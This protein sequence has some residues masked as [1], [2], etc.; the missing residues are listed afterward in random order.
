MPKKMF[1]AGLSF[2]FAVTLVVNGSSVNL[3]SVGEINNEN[4]LQPPTVVINIEPFSTIFEG[5]IV[6]C[7]ISGEVTYRFWRINDG[8]P[9]TLFYDDDPIIF[10]PDPTPLDEDYV[11]FTVYAENNDGSAQQTIKVMI[12]RLF[13]GDLHFHSRISDGRYTA[14]TMYDNAVADNYLDFAALTNHA[15][16]IDSVE[17]IAPMVFKYLLFI[18]PMVFKD[19]FQIL[20]CKLLGTSE[21]EITK[22]KADEYYDPGRFTTFLGFEYGPGPFHPG[23]HKWS[24]NGHEDISHL[25]F[26]YKDVNSDSCKYSAWTDYTYDDIFQS[27]KE[28]WDKGNLNIGFPHHPVLFNGFE[29]NTVNWTF[30]A[31]EMV[32]KESRGQVLRGVEVYSCWGTSIGK[33][34]DIPI[35]FPYPSNRIYDQMDAWVENAMWM[36]SSDSLKG[37]KFAMMASSDIHHRDRP[38]SSIPKFKQGFLD[39]IPLN[40]AGLIAVYSVH[41]T[42]DEI[43]EAINNCSMYGTQL[44]KIRANVQ[45]DGQLAYGRWINCKS[46]LKIQ[47]TAQ[48]TF[49]GTDSSGRTMCPYDFL[50]DEL[51]H[52]IKDIWI[53]KKDRDRGRPWCKVIKHFQPNED[54]VIVNYEDED[55]QPNDF[56]WIAIRQ[57]GQN[58]RNVNNNNNEIRDEYTAFIGPFFIDQ[59]IE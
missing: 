30:L 13:F 1:I 51:N 49:S 22:N 12:K 14:D 16:C 35:S 48:S 59:I 44:L 47:V 41:N 42:R 54:T 11:D 46:P 20:K 34:S 45:L 2:L 9:H 57:K 7:T 25:N 24:P 32:N 28:E 37:N 23:G 4:L 29:I 52:P 6:N 15:E 10:N 26:Y 5:D 17:F 27:M 18:A 8:E 21:W 50:P 56:Y 31:S 40:P 3:G 53:I 33:Y 39:F 43:W 58:L 38:G 19:L 55:V 36:W